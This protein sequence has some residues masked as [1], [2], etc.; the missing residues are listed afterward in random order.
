MLV[1]SAFS[2]TY[3][4]AEE[5]LR[6]PLGTPADNVQGIGHIDMDNTL[7][8]FEMTSGEDLFVNEL[9]ECESHID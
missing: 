2:E 3:Q 8:L 5:P 1:N 9:S 4:T 7:P 6:G